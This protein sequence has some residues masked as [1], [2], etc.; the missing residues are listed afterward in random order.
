MLVGRKAMTELFVVPENS[1]VNQKVFQE[2]TFLPS[3]F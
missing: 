1:F 2:K 3:V